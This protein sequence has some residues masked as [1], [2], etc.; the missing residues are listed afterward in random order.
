MGKVGISPRLSCKQ[1]G[2]YITGRLHVE[3]VCN[4]SILSDPL[5]SYSL[6]S[7]FSLNSLGKFENFESIVI[8]PNVKL[9]LIVTPLSSSQNRRFL[10]INVY[11]CEKDI[12]YILFHS[13]SRSYPVFFQKYA[14]C[15][16]IYTFRQ[17]NHV[18]CTCTVFS[19]LCVNFNKISIADD[20]RRSVGN[21]RKRTWRIVV[22]ASGALPLCFRQQSE[23]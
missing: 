20:H 18:Q 13:P 12:H 9:P 16:I 2:V 1:F 5:N 8:D 6:N 19:L 11:V 17:D 3:N 22:P 7:S 4:V 21:L 14:G 23:I 15:L 10:Q